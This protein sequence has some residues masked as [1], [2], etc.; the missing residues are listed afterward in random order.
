M[1]ND[2]TKGWT[3]KVVTQEDKKEKK[4][5]GDI[6]SI[7]ILKDESHLHVSIARTTIFI[8]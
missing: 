8:Q 6:S 7:L 5:K 1:I 3:K 2:K 4:R